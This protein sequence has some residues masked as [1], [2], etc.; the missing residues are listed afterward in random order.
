MAP[1]E[2]DL[3]DISDISG[4]WPVYGCGT[5]T[6][7]GTASSLRDKILFVFVET[8][9]RDW[10]I[11]CDNSW[12][13]NERCAY[14]RHGASH[15]W[16]FW[17]QRRPMPVIHKHAYC[18]GLVNYHVP[19]LCHGGASLQIYDLI[20]KYRNYLFPI[21]GNILISNQNN[22]GN[23]DK[24]ADLVNDGFHFMFYRPAF[25]FFYN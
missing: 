15:I 2:F 7:R 4:Y 19:W 12:S 13:D 10:W 14:V 21:S 11:V 17:H 5:H 24:K 3:G 18:W 16:L 1:N 23:K 20:L 6:R 25:D 22:K 8:P 9:H